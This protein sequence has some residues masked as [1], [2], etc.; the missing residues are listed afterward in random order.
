[1]VLKK[2]PVFYPLINL[3]TLSEVA[4]NLD[5]DDKDLPDNQLDLFWSVIY[6]C[7]ALFHWGWKASYYKNLACYFAQNFGHSW[8]VLCI[9]LPF[10]KFNL[11]THILISEL[12]FLKFWNDF[13][14]VWSDGLWHLVRWVNVFGLK[15]HVNCMVLRKWLRLHG[16]WNGLVFYLWLSKVSANQRRHYIFNTFSHQVRPCLSIDLFKKR[17]TVKGIL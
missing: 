15:T 13:V 2:L 12:E 11:L 4:L 7:R 6:W 10:A 1:M 16:C 5:S 14:N 17:D 8:R 3:E 9:K